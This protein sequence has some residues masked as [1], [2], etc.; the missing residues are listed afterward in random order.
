MGP[1]CDSGGLINTRSTGVGLPLLSRT[2]TNASP[3]SNAVITFLVSNSGLGRKV[4]ATVSTIFL[5]FGVNAL[6]AC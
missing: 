2:E 5:S 1:I 3:V 6:K 4:L